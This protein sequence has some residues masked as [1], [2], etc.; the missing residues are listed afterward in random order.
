MIN[1][2]IAVIIAVLGI[3]LVLLTKPEALEK[4]N[5]FQKIK[6]KL[7]SELGSDKLKKNPLESLRSP[8]YIIQ[9]RYKPIGYALLPLIFH[10][11]M[12]YWS[13]KLLSVIG[14]S[15]LVLYMG[16][17]AMG[18]FI[19]KLSIMV[20]YKQDRGIK[21]IIATGILM[22]AYFIA[23]S[24]W[25]T[26][27]GDNPLHVPER[28]VSDIAVEEKQDNGAVVETKSDWHLLHGSA[29][30]VQCIVPVKDGNTIFVRNTN[31]DWSATLKLADGRS[32]VR[33]YLAS[34]GN[35]SFPISFDGELI[36]ELSEKGKLE[37]SI[38]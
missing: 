16:W 37:Y 26:F 25:L 35:R 1:V 20:P 38:L 5:F 18:V 3:G 24:A 19:S 32:A 7:K 9:K 22:F 2:F 21:L 17:I 27:T 29:S 33:H 6:K 30:A 4:L 28:V 15:W 23:G 11:T 36:I 12:N 10:F 31:V 14:V 34:D 8:G 13:V